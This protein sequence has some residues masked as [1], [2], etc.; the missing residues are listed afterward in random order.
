M[1]QTALAEA[2][3]A[4][5]AGM[6]QRARTGPAAGPRNPG[7]AC[8]RQPYAWLPRG[9]VFVG[10]RSGRY[11]IERSGL[12]AILASVLLV[13]CGTAAGAVSSAP[14]RGEPAQLRLSPG[15]STAAVAA[16]TPQ[17]PRMPGAE[18]RQ[19]GRDP[20]W[21]QDCS[22]CRALAA[23]PSCSRPE[24]VTSRRCGA[25]RRRAGTG[26]VFPAV[27]RFTRVCA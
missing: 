14:A 11:S 17:R 23:P 24:P 10:S 1:E 21:S 12:P 27:A 9:K 26:G 19:A 20:G 8:R 6:Q 2:V 16:P 3:A 7:R 13:G 18:L 5:S 15:G 4:L 22:S 25:C